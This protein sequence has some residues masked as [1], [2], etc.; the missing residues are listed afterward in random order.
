MPARKL[1]EVKS[2]REQ[3]IIS[4]LF[5]YG[6]VRKKEVME[7]FDC[8]AY[9]SRNDLRE[10]RKNMMD[11]YGAQVSYSRDNDTKLIFRN[12]DE[13]IREFGDSQRRLNIAVQRLLTEGEI[14]IENYMRDFNIE[15]KIVHRDMKAVIKIF[16]DV[17]HGDVGFSRKTNGY[18]WYDRNQFI[19]RL[20]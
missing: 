5:K 1:L 12:R 11:L 10:V 8:S 14:N 6:Y 15:R 9:T 4:N 20:K 13:V 19:K 2:Y 17:Y 3:W 7:E 18:I 16:Q